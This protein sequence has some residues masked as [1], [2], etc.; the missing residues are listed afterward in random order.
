MAKLYNLAR[1]STATTGTGT[2][3]LASAVSGFLSFAASGVQDGDI[4]S[5]GINDGSNG[6]VGYGKYTASGTTLTRNPIVSTSSNNPI[7]LSGTAQVFVTGLASDFPFPDNYLTGLA[8]ANDG[9]TPN[10]VIDIAAGVAA[11]A[12]NVELMRLKTAITKSIASTWAVGSG[13]GGLD[14]GTVAASTWYHV[15]LIRRPDTG[16]VDALISTSATAPT[17]PSNYTQRRRIGSIFVNGSSNISLFTQN[18]DEFLWLTSVQDAINVSIGATNT[19]VT[20]TVP[21]GVKVNA[22]FNCFLISGAVDSGG[23]FN[24]LDQTET[25]IIGGN[26]TLTT[27]AAGEGGSGLMNIRTNTSAQVRIISNATGTRY[28]INTNGWIDTRGK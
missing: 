5:Y 9:T 18:G 27:D 6:E 16:V 26:Q 10:T 11:D 4:V 7:S 15:W 8:L 13:N 28:W 23:V 2:I 22:L 25:T 3:A 17:M 1:M 19:P 20:L 21:T 24:S 14:T 12:N